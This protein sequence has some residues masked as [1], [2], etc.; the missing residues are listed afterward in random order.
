MHLLYPFA[1][2]FIAGEN[3]QAALQSIHKLHDA[4]FL[5]SLDILGENVDSIEQAAAAKDIYVDLISKSE[6]IL[7]PMDFS[8]KLTQ[9]GLDI[10]KEF[11]KNNLESILIS[12]GN[13]TV[14]FDMEES[15]HTQATVDMCLGLHSKHKNLGQ[16][17]QAYLF[18][19]EDDINRLIENQISV[20]LCKGAYKENPSI[21]YQS[22]DD[23]RQNFL[24]LGFRLLKE[25]NMPAIAT[26]DEYLLA[27]ILA[28]IAK[29][30]ISSESFYFEMLYG[31]GRDLQS[32][33]LKKGFQVR[34]YTPFGKAWLPYTLRRLMEKKENI[35]FVMSNL[36]RE[37]FG[38]RKIK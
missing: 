7:F 27:E 25:G 17:I 14:R 11:C 15:S 3:P 34:V 36:F 19:S 1:K 4:G 8:V 26:H 29:E 5:S 24:R 13:N 33:L 22:M 9:M 38:L 30:N 10:D 35:I 12:A 2:R 16:A 37:T 31:V 28:F 32:V 21:A 6:S 18:R 20:R 23:I